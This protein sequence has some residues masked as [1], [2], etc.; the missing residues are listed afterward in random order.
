MPFVGAFRIRLDVNADI[1]V[2]LLGYRE[3]YIN[4]DTYA[5]FG[6]VIDIS[7]HA[8]TPAVGPLVGS[9][10]DAYYVIDAIG[11]GNPKTFSN[12]IHANDKAT[13]AVKV[14]LSLS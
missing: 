8:C 13:L 12:A 9:A 2:T 11:I 6:V 3:L 7:M 1:A 4:S 14:H 5:A 10:M